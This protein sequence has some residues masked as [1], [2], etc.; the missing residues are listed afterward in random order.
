MAEP[1]E[2]LLQRFEEL[3]FHNGQPDFLKT[4][5][6]DDSNKPTTDGS[7]PAAPP[8]PPRRFHNLHDAAAWIKQNWRDFDLE[9]NHPLTWRVAK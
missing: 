3:V 2:Y 9:T 5:S 7:Q 4:P 1:R 6:A 8:P